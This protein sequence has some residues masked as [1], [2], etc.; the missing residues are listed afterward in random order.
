MDE[1]TSDAR[2]L[3][4]TIASFLRALKEG[5]PTNCMR[6]QPTPPP[7]VFS[8]GAHRRGAGHELRDVRDVDGGPCHPWR[9]MPT[10][11]HAP[12][13]TPHSLTCTTLPLLACKRRKRQIVDRRPSS[14][15]CSGFGVSSAPREVGFRA[16][17]RHPLASTADAD[18]SITAPD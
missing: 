10:R 16:N 3:S 4:E 11:G 5:E 17:R 13:R 14:A 6:Q 7:P 15:I 1:D 18:P 12:G 8:A 9:R 2:P